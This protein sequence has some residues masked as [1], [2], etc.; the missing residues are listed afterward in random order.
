MVVSDNGWRIAD[1][2]RLIMTRKYASGVTRTV[3]TNLLRLSETGRFQ[4]GFVSNTSRIRFMRRS[5]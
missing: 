3:Q 5:C 2:N 1:Q 4:S